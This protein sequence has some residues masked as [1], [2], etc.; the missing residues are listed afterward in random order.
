[1]TL[2]V[3]GDPV[4]VQARPPYTGSLSHYNPVVGKPV[5]Q[6]KATNLTDCA[7]YGMRNAVAPIGVIPYEFK[8][9]GR[10]TGTVKNTP[11]TPVH[12]LVRLYREP[13]GLLVQSAWSDPIT[14]AYTF[15]GVSLDYRYTVVSFDHTEAFRA[16]IA[17]RV[18][19]EVLP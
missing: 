9:R 1:M 13:G 12:R 4:A 11:A 17:D 3:L 18:V 19:P 16:V 5:M 14:G 7:P 15:N 10:I 2:Y 6:A 8:G